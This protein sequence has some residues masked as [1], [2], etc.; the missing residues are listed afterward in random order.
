MLR[1]DVELDEEK[2]KIQLHELARVVQGEN[3]ATVDVQHLP[4]RG[5][6][7]LGPGA[8]EPEPIRESPDRHPTAAVGKNGKCRSQALVRDW[9]P[10]RAQPLRLKAGRKK[11]AL[12]PERLR[13]QFWGWRN[14]GYLGCRC[15]L[16]GSRQAFARFGLGIRRAARRRNSQAR[17]HPRLKAGEAPR[18]RLYPLPGKLAVGWWEGAGAK[19]EN[20][21]S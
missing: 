19:D 3:F 2:W 15:L 6:K 21:E 5:E 4:H 7:P 10:T 1:W 17:K 18:P 20:R 16:S 9:L 13:G 12:D 11:K 8:M 14:L